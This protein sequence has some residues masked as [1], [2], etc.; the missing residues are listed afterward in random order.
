MWVARDQKDE[1][2]WI[3]STATDSS[4]SASWLP[5]ASFPPFYVTHWVSGLDQN[6][7]SLFDKGN[8]GV[9]CAWRILWCKWKSLNLPLRRVPLCCSRALSPSLL[10]RPGSLHLHVIHP[11]SPSARPIIKSFSCCFAKCRVN[12]SRAR[13][14]RRALLHLSFTRRLRVSQCHDLRKCV[15]V[16]KALLLMVNSNSQPRALCIGQNRV[17]I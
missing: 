13:P 6:N 15:A 1:G 9:L 2:R 17:P 12:P 4:C 3:R 7:S 16:K 11:S 8:D 14:S 10:L 5:L